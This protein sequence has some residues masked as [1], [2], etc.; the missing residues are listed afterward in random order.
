MYYSLVSVQ[1]QTSLFRACRNCRTKL[2]KPSVTVNGVAA[3]LSRNALT[4]VWTGSAVIT[5]T[6]EA[7][8]T[9]TATHSEGATDTA[10]VTIEAAPVISQLEF[11]GAY[12]QGVDQT[13]HA[14]GQTV[15][16]TIASD[17]PFTELEI[18]DDAGTA[19]EA[20]NL[21]FAATTTKTVTVTVADRGSYGTGA[22]II[23]P[24]K[25]RIKSANGDM[26]RLF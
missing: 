17:T 4:D 3:T 18:V 7:P 5:L 20:L 26:G 14:Q 23:V 11:S 2:F 8:Y 16:L 13:E 21:S 10:T 22:P 25:A 19:T 6:G 15:S 1:H 9:V 24:A 12:S